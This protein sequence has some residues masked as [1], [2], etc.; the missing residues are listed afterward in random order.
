MNAASA[1]ESTNFDE[2]A[3]RRYPDIV[4]T[5]DRLGRPVSVADAQIAAICRAAGA[6]LAT[7]NTDDFEGTEVQLVNPWT[8]G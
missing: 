3:A 7:R 4:A 6:A 5:R 2:P 8:L 1:A